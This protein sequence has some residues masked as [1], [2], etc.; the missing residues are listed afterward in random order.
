MA[1]W[2]Y[3]KRAVT[4][5]PNLD[6]LGEQGWELV[7]VSEGV[8]FFKRYQNYDQLR[9][10]VA[11]EG[12]NI[13]GGW[14]ADESKGQKKIESITSLDAGPDGTSHKHRAAVVVGPNMEVIVGTTDTVNGHSHGI[15]MVGVTAEAD[16]H[17]HT[18]GVY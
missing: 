16:G 17:T 8:M 7:A 1:G 13:V 12:Q 4:D 6:S 14:V 18:F 15:N 9:P 5:I 2:N 3:L 10:N 11:A